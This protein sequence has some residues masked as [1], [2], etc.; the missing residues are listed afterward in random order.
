[1]NAQWAR[2]T[3]RLNAMSV[4]E[5]FMLFV[6]VVALL[7]AL[8]DA[9]FI[10]PLTRLQKQHAVQIDKRSASLEGERQRIELQLARSRQGRAEELGAEIARVQ[11]DIDTVE[12][13]IASLSASARDAVAMR[14][15][16]TRTLGRTDKVSLL[17]V[18]SA[19]PGAAPA[20]GAASAAAIGLDIT[21]A[22]RY[23]DLMDQLAELEQALPQARWSA[24]RFTAETIP[25][26]A[27]VRIATLNE[28][29]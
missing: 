18:S 19:A 29:P 15:T 28:G 14:A 24:L 3:A 5:R 26:Q 6:A 25:P 13:E 8:I 2:A 7:G 9:V 4:R 1:M 21:L 16:L 10:T 23:L 20:A 22:G 27:T 11:A 12:R 17:R